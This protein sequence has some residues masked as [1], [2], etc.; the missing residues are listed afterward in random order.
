MGCSASAAAGRRANIFVEK[1]KTPSKYTTEEAQRKLK[2]CLDEH[3]HLVDTA[4]TTDPLWLVADSQVYKER[5]RLCAICRVAPV[6]AEK[7][8]PGEPYHICGGFRSSAVDACCDAHFIYCTSCYS[9]ELVGHPQRLSSLAPIADLF[10]KK[11]IALVHVTAFLAHVE[12]GNKLQRRQDFA[13]NF[14][15]MYVDDFS[16]FACGAYPLF[17]VSAA[18]QIPEHPD[19][20]NFTAKKIAEKVREHPM[21]SNGCLFWDFISLAQP[22]KPGT[23]RKGAELEALKTF[24]YASDALFANVHPR[25][26]FVRCTVQPDDIAIDPERVVRARGW[27]NYENL[28]IGTVPKNQ[29]ID[30]A[31]AKKTDRQT[32][33]WAR[34]SKV[35]MSPADF[36]AF[37][38]LPDPPE[39]S[40]APM[41][42]YA[43]SERG[44]G[45]SEVDEGEMEGGDAED[46]LRRA[47]TDFEDLLLSPGGISTPGGG[48]GGSSDGLDGRRASTFSQRRSTTN[49]DD[50]SSSRRRGR[51]RSS[52]K[53]KGRRNSAR[54]GSRRNSYRRSSVRSDTSGDT[55]RDSIEPVPEH[56]FFARE[57]DRILLPEV[58]EKIA[59][60][61]AIQMEELVIDEKV[62]GN[63]YL[64]FRLSEF[65]LFVVEQQQQKKDVY[66]KR[67]RLQKT[68]LDSVSLA[69]LARAI[70]SIPFLQR[71]E[72][73]DNDSLQDE[74]VESLTEELLLRHSQR[75]Q[76]SEEGE[77]KEKS[78]TMNL[79]LNWL[80]LSGCTFVTD[81]SIPS[82]T[83]L[84]RKSPN[85]LVGVGKTGLSEKGK[86]QLN[87][88]RTAA[89]LQRGTGA[90]SD[91]RRHTRKKT[92]RVSFGA[93]QSLQTFE[94]NKSGP[95]AEEKDPLGKI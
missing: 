59:T 75:L 90:R 14:P 82:L 50:E 9:K 51:R 37:C 71:L 61:R 15:A 47:E 46:V 79:S 21:A 86:Q 27:M 52:A 94:A 40:E 17:V 49:V 35:P 58:Y 4:V 32:E 20:D 34:A 1:P 41:S 7:D 66:L 48:A 24:A 70:A 31:P 29:I 22:E 8:K 38:A 25:V 43:Q 55:V 28:L 88:A 65:I 77:D 63:P 80:N 11:T 56:W 16:A 45:K 42:E 60:S 89:A 92:T 3:F 91:T 39:P 53:S 6:G 85:L 23:E 84:I 54:R 19:P 2:K 73:G 44:G 74:G 78:G 68:R 30:V 36:S 76:E 72:L 12:A 13:S 26:F 57:E 10:S 69:F 95:K 81:A 93:L 67:L 18:W 64:V 33:A 87:D 83:R 5:A 62:L